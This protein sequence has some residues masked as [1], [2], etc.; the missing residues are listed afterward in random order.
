MRLF[1][2]ASNPVTCAD[3]G[4]HI[5]NAM[6]LEVQLVEIDRDLRGQLRELKLAH[7][8]RGKSRLDRLNRAAQADIR[9]RI[10]PRQDGGQG[11]RFSTDV[12][13]GVPGTVD[14]VEVY[15]AY[16]TGLKS[17][18]KLP[19]VPPYMHYRSTADVGPTHLNSAFDTVMRAEA[20]DGLVEGMLAQPFWDR[21]LRT[22]H[23]GRFQASLARA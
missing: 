12:I 2:M 17:R 10:K 19:W 15:L 9:Q 21:Y 18:L 8:A 1:Q 4:A 23:A 3:A 22:T 16:H 14:E 13:D 7:L 20:H 5:F 11:L 6:G